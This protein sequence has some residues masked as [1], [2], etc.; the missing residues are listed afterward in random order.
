MGW[1]RHGIGWVRA[2]RAG[3]CNGKLSNEPA[4]TAPQQTK[5]CA[6]DSAMR[7][8]LS[9]SASWILAPSGRLHAPKHPR[10]SEDKIIIL[11]GDAL[12]T[13][14]PFSRDG[15]IQTSGMSRSS[16]RQV[17][18]HRRPGNHHWMLGLPFLMTPPTF[19]RGHKEIAL[20]ARIPN[21]DSAAAHGFSAVSSGGIWANYSSRE[22]CVVIEQGDV[23]LCGF[24]F[25]PATRRAPCLTRRTRRSRSLGCTPR[26]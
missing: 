22:P 14:R 24:F 15:R 7:S 21:D 26:V 20:R 19:H 1:R 17:S 18:T 5:S 23:Q 9:R 6:G 25:R 10:V 16:T 4:S 8:T 13:L 3:P 12:R 2:N 11:F